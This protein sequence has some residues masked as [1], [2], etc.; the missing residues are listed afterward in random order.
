MTRYLGE[1]PL[2]EDNPFKDHTLVDW[3]MTY[4]EAYGQIDG[5]HHK[6]WVLDQVARI[7]KGEMVPTVTLAKWSDGTREYRFTLHEQ[8][9]SEKYLSWVKTRLGE[10][11]EENEEHEYFYEE[12][13]AP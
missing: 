2:E 1:F 9:P 5:D 13:I 12:G 11:D 6:S 3:A 10:Y 8:T 4:I 7:L